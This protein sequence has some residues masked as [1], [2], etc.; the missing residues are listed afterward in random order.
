M[1]DSVE[2]KQ[3][4]QAFNLYIAKVTKYLGVTRTR[5]IY[6]KA[7]ETLKAY[8]FLKFGIRFANLEKKLGEIDRARQLFGYISQAA[9]P[10][11]DEYSFWN[12]YE[13]FEIEC[14]NEDTFKEM[15]R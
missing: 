12:Q 6:K 5:P 14:G 15:M 3:K 13:E 7:I 8:D 2:M 1:V 9:D 4:P 11:L 10:N